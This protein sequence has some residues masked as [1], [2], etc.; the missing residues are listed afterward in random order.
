MSIMKWSVVRTNID[1]EGQAELLSKEYDDLEDAIKAE[2]E[3]VK[4]T[5][6]I[7]TEQDADQLGEGTRA[8]GSINVVRHE[9]YVQIVVRVF[10]DVD[11]GANEAN[12]GQAD[13]LIFVEA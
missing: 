13:I 9:T 7:V 3:F 6:D 4:E 1:G 12:D 10:Y 2:I 5:N 8:T 11:M